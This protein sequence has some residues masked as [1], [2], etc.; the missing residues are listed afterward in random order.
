MTLAPA[1]RSSPLETVLTVP[2]VPTGMKTGVG[3]SPRDVWMTPARGPPLAA[4]CRT[5]KNLFA[6][7]ANFQQVG[8][9]GAFAGNLGNDPARRARGEQRRDARTVTRQEAVG[10]RHDADRD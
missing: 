6:G 7:T 8:E 3:I 9:I 1:V 5:S 2:W 4:R 10:M